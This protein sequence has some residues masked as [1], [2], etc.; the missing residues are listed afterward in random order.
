MKNAFKL[1]SLLFV[2]L[3]LFQVS[4]SE[5]DPAPAPVDEIIGKWALSSATYISDNVPATDV[6]TITNFP[7]LQ[8]P[9]TLELPTGADVTAIVVGAMAN[10]VCTD[11]TN[12]AT[13]FLELTADGK[14]YLNCPAE[15]VSEASGTW[16]KTEDSTNG[17][18]ITLNVEA[19]GTT[20][21]ISFVNYNMASDKGSFTGT[22]SGY[23]MVI[24]F[25]EDLSAT[26]LQFLTS[27]MGFTR[28]P[29]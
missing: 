25:A 18:V 19:A 28:I 27:N 3:I 16:A 1:S 10:G 7:T 17:T 23:P 13:F 22:T 24:D 11:P 15:M 21:P 26:N 6:L 2:G 8:G 29:E 14:L 9:I 20:L 4:C 12:Y 5:D